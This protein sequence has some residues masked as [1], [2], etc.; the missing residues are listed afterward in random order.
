MRHI[1][2]KHK[3]KH[4]HKHLHLHLHLHFIK[5]LRIQLI[6]SALIVDSVCFGATSLPLLLIVSI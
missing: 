5:E 2:C 3:H 1:S 6:P 4:K